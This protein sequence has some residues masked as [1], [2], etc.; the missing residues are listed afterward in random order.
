MF[1]PEPWAEA[2]YNTAG[3]A[4]FA[5]EALEYLVI[6][7]HAAL[8]LPGNISGRTNADRL[9]KM[10]RT[11]LSRNG[12]NNVPGAELALHYI[13]IMVRRS[14]LYQQKSIIHC[15]EKKINK[16]KGIEEVVVETAVEPE[17][18]LLALIKE[19]AK[20]LTGANEVKLNAKIIPDL[21]GGIRL[22]WGNMVIDSSIKRSLQ[23]MELHLGA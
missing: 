14:Y 12:E 5:E 2:F 21:I 4:A 8:A 15:I 7:C 19:K 11:A 23:N 9:G 22:R 17:E 1:K 16:Q 18:Q 10:L 3:S 20:A 13:Q 6:F